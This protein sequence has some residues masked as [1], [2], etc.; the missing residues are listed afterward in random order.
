MIFQKPFLF[1]THSHSLSL[2]HIR[3]HF[4]GKYDLASCDLFLFLP[5][6]NFHTKAPVERVHFKL[7]FR[8]FNA[9][10]NELISETNCILQSENND[11][12]H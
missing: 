9:L 4:V 7:Q 2:L 8:T 10:T 5:L 3:T 1:N 11:K 6:S 12:T